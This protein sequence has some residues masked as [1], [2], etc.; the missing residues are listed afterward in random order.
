MQAAPGGAGSEASSSHGSLPDS[1]VDEARRER[2]RARRQRNRAAR[3][4]RLEAERMQDEQALAALTPEERAQHEEA[5][6]AARQQR[7][8][9][10]L[11]QQDK[12]QRAL[13]DGVM[14]AIECSLNEGA[15]DREMRSLGRQIELSMVANRRASVP[16]ALT[17][18]GCRGALGEYLPQIGAATWPCNF[19]AATVV[20]HVLSDARPDIAR[21][22]V[23]SPDAPDELAGA[24]DPATCYVV[25]GM[26]DRSVRSGTTLKWAEE[27]AATSPVPVET[28][29]LP[30][31]A[32]LGKDATVV[33][34]VNTVVEILLARLA[35]EPW[36][37]AVRAALPPRKVAQA[38]TAKPPGWRTDGSADDAAL[39]ALPGLADALA[40]LDRRLAQE[41][42]P[43]DPAARVG[44][45][46]KVP[47]GPDPLL[48]LIREVEQGV[49]AG[50]SQAAA[51]AGPGASSG[52]G[53]SGGVAGLGGGKGLPQ[54]K[55]RSKRVSR[56][57]P[58]APE[59]PEIVPVARGGG[60]RGGDGA[61]G[62]GAGGEDE[63]GWTAGDAAV[64]GVVVAVV[65]GAAAA[66]AWRNREAIGEWWRGLALPSWVPGSA[67]RA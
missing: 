49:S 9:A 40:N 14:I 43:A 62:G 52:A 4:A 30:T 35:G 12:V 34:N 32:A 17:V 13:K 36:D 8:A 10:H 24:L 50:G 64:L 25:G 59:R 67:K 39:A 61:G 18:T 20:E 42:A 46:E 48:A 41:R 65:G 56:A 27:V 5:S 44:A 55:G 28:R 38:G 58:G 11:A 31:A 45:P 19:A 3:K 63:E 2:N 21:L 15:S 57:G 51:T 7:V 53:P 33:L 60:R 37:A 6:D 66:V 16:A 23:L 1:A 29:R 22:V 54:R 26:A 47:G